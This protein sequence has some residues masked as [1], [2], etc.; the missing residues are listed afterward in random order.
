MIE[1]IIGGLVVDSYIDY[2]IRKS[3]ETKEQKQKSEQL[4]LESKCKNK[5]SAA[6]RRGYTNSKCICG[7]CK[8]GGRK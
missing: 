7:S 3:Q 5:R 8:S 4:R 2:K 1:W 6:L